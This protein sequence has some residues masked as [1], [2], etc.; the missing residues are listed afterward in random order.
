TKRGRSLAEG[1]TSFNLRTEYGSST[2]PHLIPTNMHHDYQV[3]KDASGKVTGF[4]LDKNGNRQE[5]A[6]QIAQQSYP[7]VYDQ[8]REVFRPGA[9]LTNYASVGERHGTTNLNASFQ[10]TRESGVL[11]LL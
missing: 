2:L 6:D 9:F 5:T 4:L 3:T 11:A 8:Y 10:N 7:V 1:Q